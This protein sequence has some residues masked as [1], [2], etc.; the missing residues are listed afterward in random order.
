[1]Y[2]FPVW[3]EPPV[4]D[5]LFD[6]E[7]SFAVPGLMQKLRRLCQALDIDVGSIGGPEWPAMWM[8]IGV[9]LAYKHGGLKPRGRK[10]MQSPGAR[11]DVEVVK[12]IEYV[13]EKRGLSFDDLLPLGI[14][15]ATQQGQLTPADRTTDP[16][17]LN[18][19]KR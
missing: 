13:A 18:R 16:K 15:W 14:E 17:R 12:A 6:P 3:R 2:N 9:L 8:T 19:V 7:R 11:I 5:W 10:K 1:M 4:R